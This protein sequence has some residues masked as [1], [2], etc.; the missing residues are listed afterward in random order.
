MAGRHHDTDN[1]VKPG[2]DVNDPFK[3]TVQHK[4]SGCLTI[5]IV[6]I[7]PEQLETGKQK[8]RKH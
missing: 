1:K 8:Q 6:H 7:K 5:K 4:S 2:D 3:T